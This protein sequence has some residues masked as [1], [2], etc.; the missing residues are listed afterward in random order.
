M[1]SFLKN[2]IFNVMR[3][4][5]QSPNDNPVEKI[6]VVCT[7]NNGEVYINE[8]TAT[9]TQPQAQE[10]NEDQVGGSINDKPIRDQ[11]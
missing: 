1:P 6:P 8:I 4:I 7:G 2:Q 11:R 10:G 9:A 3:R 5:S